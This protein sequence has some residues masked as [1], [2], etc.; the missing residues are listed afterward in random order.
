MK[1]QIALLIILL[2]A[3]SV[4]RC[5]DDTKPELEIDKT[6]INLAPLANS[7][8]SITIRSNTDWTVSTDASWLTIT[9]ASGNGNATIRIV[10][11]ANTD[12]GERTATILIKVK[13]LDD[14]TLQVIQGGKFYVLPREVLLD[15]TVN[16]R[17][18]LWVYSPGEWSASTTSNWLEIS[19]SSGTQS[20]FIVVRSL[21]N[22]PDTASRSAHIILL[23]KDAGKDTISIKQRGT[24]YYLSLSVTSLS[25]GPESNKT[26][27]FTISSNT[28]WSLSS[29]LESLTVSPLSGKGN[30]TIMVKTNSTM[31]VSRARTMTLTITGN[32]TKSQKIKIT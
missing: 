17:D 27:T 26:A 15:S 4:I 24:Q 11:E 6:T 13:G 20:G 22:N 2:S 25:L 5:D 29:P 10:A 28:S 7:L 31:T 3:Y 14:K 18:T 1:K 23:Q 21:S 8:D 9:P 30:A 12:V 32:Y 19:P 16:S